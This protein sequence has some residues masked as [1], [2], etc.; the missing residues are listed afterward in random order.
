MTLSF[1]KLA[2]LFVIVVIG[3]I[4]AVQFKYSRESIVR[5]KGHQKLAFS[6]VELEAR[7]K[8]TKGGKEAK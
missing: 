5:C 7:R 1:R 8:R 2:N 6:N 4:Y 3:K